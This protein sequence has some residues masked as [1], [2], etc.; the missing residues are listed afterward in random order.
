MHHKI[1]TEKIGKRFKDFVNS[2]EYDPYEVAVLCNQI[3]KEN[4]VE[5]TGSKYVTGILLFDEE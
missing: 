3:L 2:Q 1:I 4:R 5:S